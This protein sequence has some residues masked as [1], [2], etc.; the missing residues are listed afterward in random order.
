MRKWNNDFR[1]VDCCWEQSTAVMDRNGDE[2]LEWVP[3]DVTAVP[4][5]WLMRE[6]DDLVFEL[7]E[8]EEKLYMLKAKI[9]GKEEL[10]LKETDFKQ[11]YGANNQKVRDNHVR[12][13]LE[14]DFQ[15][16]HDLE[17]SIDFIGRRI[18]FL[19]E[20]VRCKRVLLEV[21]EG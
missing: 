3:V 17:M 9:Q 21:K 15:V 10:I 18:S 11:L 5:I 13:L 8:K 12:G 7:S 1:C 20:L 19:R 16:K 2:S 14:S 6:W 4:V